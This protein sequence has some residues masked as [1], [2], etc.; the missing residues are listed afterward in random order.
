MA[1]IHAAQG[2]EEAAMELAMQ[3]EK[4]PAVTQDTKDRAIQLRT[5]LEDR[6]T[7]QQIESI[8]ARADANTFENVVGDL[9]K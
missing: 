1:E 6:L 5:E 4:H 9:I 2:R 7:Q 8:Q 3:V